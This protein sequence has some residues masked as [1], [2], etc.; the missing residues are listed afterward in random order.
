MENG[1]QQCAKGVFM[2]LGS[3]PCYYNTGI[4][5][6]QENL[7]FHLWSIGEYV[8]RIQLWGNKPVRYLCWFLQNTSSALLTSHITSLCCR[9]PILGV[10]REEFVVQWFFFSAS[11]VSFLLF[12]RRRKIK[13]RDLRPLLNTKRKK[14]R[15]V[16]ALFLHIKAFQKCW[17]ML[18]EHFISNV[19]LCFLECKIIIL[20]LVE[21]LFGSETRHFKIWLVLL[22]N[23]RFQKP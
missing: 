16:H 14:Q 5:C 18:C 23:C 20:Q 4:K 19:S 3:D 15:Q 11:K 12:W 2:C 6:T 22:D 21:Y 7:Y 8:R 9:A 17:V 10:Q 1:L 13:P